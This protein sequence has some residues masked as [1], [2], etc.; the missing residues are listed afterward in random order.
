MKHTFR[1]NEY[2]NNVFPS[3]IPIEKTGLPPDTDGVRFNC[4]FS[5]CDECRISILIK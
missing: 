2:I 4:D 3:L 5:I 1:L